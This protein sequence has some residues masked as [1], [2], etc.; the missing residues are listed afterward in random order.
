MGEVYRAEDLK[1]GQVVALKFL[2]DAIAHSASA[3]QRFISEV[4]L[5][6]QVSHPN[7]C[8]LYDLIE[9]DGRHALSM[10]FIDGEDLATRLARR[11]PL[12]RTELVQL[13][14]DLCAG[15]G[16]AHERGVVHRD[17]KPANILID[18]DGRA[19]IAD[20]GIAALAA[21][22]RTSDFSGTLVY[23]APE[24]LE[25]GAASPRSDL[26]AMALAL[27][28]AAS[29]KRR[30]NAR[31]LDELKAQHAAGGGRVRAALRRAPAGVQRL[32][33][34]CLAAQPSDRPADARAAADF[35]MTESWWPRPK[36]MA[37]AAL[38]LLLVFGGL[39]WMGWK[40]GWVAAG[41]AAGAPARLG[42]ASAA[43]LP[44]VNLSGQK[45]DDYFS[46]GMSDTLLDKLSQVPQ[47]RIAARTSSF[48]FKG[49]PASVAEIGTALGVAALV[50]GSVQRQGDTLRISAELIR[51]S[52]GTRLWSQHYDRKAQDLFAIQDEIAGAVTTALVG[53]LLPSSKAALAKRGTE[54]LV[55]YQAYIQGHQALSRVSMDSFQR[56]EKLLRTAV[57]RDP[58]YIPAMLDLAQCWGWLYSLGAYD[59][60]EFQR[61]AGPML[62][63]V[64]AI[65]PGNA[66]V[67][68]LRAWLAQTRQE[69]ELAIK[70]V[71]RAVALSPDDYGVRV[72]AAGAYA[73]NGDL[74]GAL[75]HI[76]RMVALD[77]LNP[78][79]LSQRAMLL[80]LMG[81]L[82]EAEAAALHALK[83]QPHDLVALATMAN[84]AVARN[85]LLGGLVWAFRIFPNNVDPG[86][87]VDLAFNLE[88]IG[89]SAEAD[90]WL[91][92]SRLLQPQN[93]IRAD[94]YEV[95]R[96]FIRGDDARC[97]E[98]ARNLLEARREHWDPIW[99][100]TLGLACQASARQGKLEA[101]R[102]EL[103][104]AGLMP[105]KA[106]AASLLAW[107]GTGQAG[108]AKLEGLDAF[109]S[110]TFTASTED[111][112]RR[113]ALREAYK[114]FTPV[115]PPTGEEAQMRDARLRDDRRAIAA[116]LAK[117]NAISWY[118]EAEAEMSGVADD[119][120]VRERLR[121][122]RS[123]RAKVHDGLPGALAKAGLSM[124]PPPP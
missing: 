2:P 62:D 10:E 61:R 119:P 17:L 100:D 88:S 120:A 15:L 47:L 26:Y 1:L 116:I 70:L 112:S 25:G 121:E 90:A 19:H 97:Q 59:A 78:Y 89:Y 51:V 86:L 79:G 57:D 84:I 71:D 8:R 23:M 54:D 118:L 33:N 48:A 28:E 4:K 91:R 72:N 5:G 104:R 39:G 27:Y 98:A 99:N 30:F 16:A 41:I 24:Q 43:V 107:A 83:L 67:L 123:D 40:R 32:V 36:Q 106:D 80:K 93:N 73:N 45:S 92:R 114:A 115:K 50:E 60:V 111:R 82:E 94:S 81:R 35:L 64:D 68:G 6:R 96:Q 102:S 13:A 103:A 75:R 87:A 74:P 113:E 29:G 76:D 7:V 49:K 108:R 122:R 22:A 95:T 37:A 20:F 46:D 124:L 56:A 77:P 21:D 53:K 42:P 69:K 18:R 9:V 110:C 65:D 105:A 66:R 117:S 38:L 85:D 101:M 11:G 55:A 52:D 14:S 63:R 3:L 34:A 109:K 44:F 31:N 58:H 12:A